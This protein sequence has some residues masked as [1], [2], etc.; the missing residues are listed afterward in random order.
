MSTEAGA[1]QTDERGTLVLRPAAAG[2]EQCRWVTEAGALRWQGG[3][4]PQKP[5]KGWMNDDLEATRDL[6]WLVDQLPRMSGRQI[7]GLGAA[8]YPSITRLYY[9][10]MAPKW[11]NNPHPPFLDWTDHV[12][13]S[14]LFYRTVDADYAIR[15]QYCAYRMATNPALTSP[16]QPGSR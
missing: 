15:P 2:V 3:N 16:C 6:S 14:G 7:P 4:D 9:Y 1:L 8:R 10:H 11:A 13:D 12:W 5:Y